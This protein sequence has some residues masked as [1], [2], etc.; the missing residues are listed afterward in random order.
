MVVGSDKTR[1]WY[2]SIWCFLAIVF[3]VPSFSD[4][5]VATEP[6]QVYLSATSGS[7]EDIFELSVVSNSSGGVSQ[8]RFEPSADFSVSYAGQSSQIQVVNGIATSEMRHLFLLKPKRIGEL[9][10]PKGIIQIAGQAHE[11]ASLPVRIDTRTKERG[12]KNSSNGDEQISLS[13]DLSRTSVYV[14]EQ[15]ISTLE[16]SSDS[17]IHQGSFDELTYDQFWK[18]DLSRPRP[19]MRQRNGQ[20]TYLHQIRHALFPLTPGSLVIPPAKLQLRVERKRP[21]S[22]RFS[23]FDSGFLRMSQIEDVTVISESTPLEVLP[24]PTLP[25]SMSDGGAHPHIPVGEVAISLGLNTEPIEA[26]QSKTVTISIESDG[27]IRP[28]DKL[29]LDVPESIS[30]YADTPVDT[31]ISTTERFRMKRTYKLSLVPKKGGTFDI[32]GVAIRFFNP[33]LRQYA[34]AK[35]RDIRLIATSQPASAVLQGAPAERPRTRE[36]IEQG[37]SKERVIYRYREESLIERLSRSISLSLALFTASMVILLI[38]CVNAILRLRVKRPQQGTPS[39][40]AG[41][42]AHPLQL[43]EHFIERLS[44]LLGAKDGE[45][46]RG[47][48][49]EQEIDSHILSEQ[50][51]IILSRH[52]ERLDSASYGSEVD[53]GNQEELKHLLS[54]S[55]SILNEVSK[56][57]NGG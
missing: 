12:E 4:T 11:I 33:K 15:L 26:G 36:D 30:V 2:S 10:T 17:K 53:A 6:P 56:C 18:E 54:E 22:G 50:L 32:P 46:F 13:R 19:E 48:H 41:D 16:L 44:S 21:L 51:K 3:Y 28:I 34:W 29:S 40:L 57:S 9:E 55:Q 20:T 8:P 45:S 42:F 31:D 24:L 38:F 52:L 14:G 25:E 23:F 49:L 5:A 35:T 47:Y 1:K 43:R 39:V 27:N 37:E 7:L